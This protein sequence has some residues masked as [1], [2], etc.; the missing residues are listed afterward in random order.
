MHLTLGGSSLTEPVSVLSRDSSMQQENTVW[1]D[2]SHFDQ[3][4]SHTFG[5]FPEI[6]FQ[7]TGP[8]LAATQSA[9][10][11][12][13]IFA[14]KESLRYLQFFHFNLPTPTHQIGI[15]DVKYMCK[16]S[17]W[18]ETIMCYADPA[19]HQN[20]ERGISQMVAIL[21][22][23]FMQ[24][25]YPIYYAYNFKEYLFLARKGSFEFHL[26]SKPT[27]ALIRFVSL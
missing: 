18:N 21:R 8:L 22:S 24:S 14:L 3:E 20:L 6:I 11:G 4:T 13:T 19:G 27:S 5:E 26:S 2:P 9:C 12:R 23:F 7:F 25:E 17:I 1:S 16:T 10:H 15:R